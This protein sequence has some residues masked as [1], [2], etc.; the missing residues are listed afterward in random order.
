LK[1]YLKSYPFLFAI[2]G[3]LVIIDQVSK[4]YV[5]AH[6]ALGETWMPLEWLAPYARIV[7]WSNTG[8]AFG[9]FQGMNEVFKVLAMLVALAIIF[10]FPR[11]PEKDWTLRVAMGMQLG[12]AVGNLIDRFS[13]GHV[14]DFVSIGNFPVFNV[15]DSSITVGVG[16]LLLGLWLDE[17]KKK[18]DL[19][20]AETPENPPMDVN[21]E[22]DS[23]L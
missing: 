21:P 23:I 4:A 15:A 16:V 12:G 10:Y 19:P 11:V 13:S 1:K 6:L 7:H 8:V 17:R 9:M 18:K 22:G 14:L 2:A 3:F 5:R 20:S